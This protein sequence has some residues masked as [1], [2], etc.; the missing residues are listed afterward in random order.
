MLEIGLG[1]DMN[2]GPGKSYYTWLE[3]F[4]HVDLYYIEYDAACAE[5][6][7]HKT[8]RATVYTG[9]QADVVFLERFLNETGGRFDV[10]IDDGGHTSQFSFPS[11]LISFPR[12]GE[13][14]TAN[15]GGPKSW[16][17]C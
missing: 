17:Q 6:W 13:R 8:E 16:K 10:I 4:P 9:D 12:E 7:K 1:C 5:Q 2:Y 15:W 11:G 3:Y 14:E